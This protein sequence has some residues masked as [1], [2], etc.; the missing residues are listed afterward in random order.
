[1]ATHSQ[2]AHQDIAYTH[3]THAYIM[4][5]GDKESVRAGRW[6]GIPPR[7]RQMLAHMAGIGSKKG[8]TTLQSLNALERGKLHCEARRL[9]KQLEI[10]LRCAQGGDLSSQFPT[11]GH[12]SDG[13]VA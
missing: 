9:I 6:N 12:E 4:L 13:I 1:M 7:D 8:D 10:V 2:Q 3:L 11:A 5:A